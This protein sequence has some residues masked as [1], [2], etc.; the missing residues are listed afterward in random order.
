MNN[1]KIVATRL[2]RTGLLFCLLLMF[3]GEHAFAQKNKRKTRI[4]INTGG[5]SSFHWQNGRHAL[6]VEFEGDLEWLDDDS[7]IKSMTRGSFLEIEEKMPSERHRL[8]VEGASGDELVYTYRRNGKRRAFDE[9][10]QEWFAEVLPTFIR[11]SGLG[12]ESRTKRILDTDGVDGVLDEADLIN[13]PGVKSLYLLYLFD[14]AELNARET[15]RAAQIASGISS[16]GDK[17]RFLKATA[18]A[19][20]MHDEA[21]EDYFQ[22][23]RSI[24]SPG[25][26]TRVL[27]P[28]C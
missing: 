18:K 13:S 7:G 2:M 4:S 23:V 15:T 8:R 1:H 26:K 6:K 11:E 24:S 3:C 20:L 27:D 9:E 17:S 5:K 21:T 19:F 14:F 16:P 25:D 22:A 10:A 28:P 12:A